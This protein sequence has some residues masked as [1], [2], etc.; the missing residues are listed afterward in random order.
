MSEEKI[1]YLV[2]FAMLFFIVYS[3]FFF[4]SK[5][6]GYLEND[7]KEIFLISLYYWLKFVFLAVII[8]FGE[9]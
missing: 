5:V 9:V 6:E 3:A 8:W 1:F 7:H 2:F 4:K